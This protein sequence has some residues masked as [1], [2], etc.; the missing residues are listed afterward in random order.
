MFSSHYVWLYLTE[1]RNTPLAEAKRTI[2]LRAPELMNGNC[3]E[4]HST[5]DTVWLRVPD[6][7]AA[8]DDVRGGRVSCASE[9]CHGLA[10]PF[11]RDPGEKR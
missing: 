7:K 1:Y 10:H 4:C 3:M 8:L 6:H 2:R 9:G 11:F 5:R